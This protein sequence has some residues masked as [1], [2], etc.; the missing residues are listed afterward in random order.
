MTPRERAWIAA[1]AAGEKYANTSTFHRRQNNAIIA[2]IEAYF[3]TF[4]GAYAVERDDAPQQPPA[5]TELEES[6]ARIA[7]LE[8]LVKLADAMHDGAQ[9]NAGWALRRR[10][11]IARS[12]IVLTSDM[13]KEG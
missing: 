9:G 10:Y 11:Q 7:Q 3:L 1:N 2:M 4:V 5:S 12:Q 6:R 13:K 8:E